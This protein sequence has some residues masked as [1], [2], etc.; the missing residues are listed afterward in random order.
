M[1]R[2]FFPEICSIV[3]PSFYEKLPIFGRDFDQELF[4]PE[5][6]LPS[7]VIVI[8]DVVVI[9]VLFCTIRFVGKKIEFFIMW[10]TIPQRK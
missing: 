4:S 8:G 2:P 6:F 1:A 10:L 5:S 7:L 9:V 3:I